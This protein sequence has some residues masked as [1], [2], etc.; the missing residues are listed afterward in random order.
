[1]ATELMPPGSATVHK[2]APAPGATLA[3][4]YGALSYLVFVGSIVYSIGFVEN[5]GVPTTIDAG[6]PASLLA[7][8][9]ID[10]GL[11]AAFV[12]QHT[13]M[14]RPRFKAW[15]TAILPESIERST[16]VL[17]ASFALLL[18]FWQWRTLPGVIWQVDNV[19]VRWVL[20]GLSLLGWL[21]VLISSFLVSHVDLFG[22]RQVYFAWRRITYTSL[23]FRI[24][25]LYRLVRHP[26][27]LGFLIAFWATPRMTAGHLL[28][29]LASTGYIIF[30]VRF[31]EERDLV[32]AFGDTYLAYRQR[33]PML[34]PLARWHKR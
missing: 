32:A 20:I 24:A 15:W 28:F 17:L 4:V 14:A 30:A 18:L 34:L 8:V 1:M 12:A 25:G 5:F 2:P 19:T 16:F 26:M 22:L 23:P 21:I 3:L 13:I 9:L 27:M 31:L 29:A 6:R 10:A 7:G 33:V 11:L